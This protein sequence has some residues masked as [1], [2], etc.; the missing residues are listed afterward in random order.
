MKKEDP[1]GECKLSFESLILKWEG[2]AYEL[3]GHIE[4]KGG[5][6]AGQI[7]SG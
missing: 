7:W 4:S 3:C 2:T 1:E 6:S 5:D